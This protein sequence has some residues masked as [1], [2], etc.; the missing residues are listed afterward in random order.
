MKKENRINKSLIIGVAGLGLCLLIIAIVLLTVKSSDVDI[1]EKLE[2][3]QKYLKT[4][5][6]FISNR[7]VHR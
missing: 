3:G 7:S 6:V 5:E 2:L 4:V 1:T